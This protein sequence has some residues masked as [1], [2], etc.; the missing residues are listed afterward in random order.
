MDQGS[1]GEANDNGGDPATDAGAGYG[2]QIWMC[3]Q[4]GAYR[5][6]GAGGQY[7]IVLPKQDIVIATNQTGE[8]PLQLELMWKMLEEIEGEDDPAESQ[9][10]RFFCDTR[11]LPR[12][13]S[14]PVHRAPS[15]TARL[16]PLRTMIGSCS[17]QYSARLH[18]RYQKE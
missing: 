3:K 12:Q 4:D 18:I 7:V 13:A 17:R 16:I 15:C 6:I 8:P 11:A 10:L 5:F 9:A 14:G 1:Y 2:Y